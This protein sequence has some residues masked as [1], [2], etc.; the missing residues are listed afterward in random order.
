MV[1]KNRDKKSNEFARFGRQEKVLLNNTLDLEK[2]WK[3]RLLAV[4]RAKATFL[5]KLMV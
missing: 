3:V 1:K 2:V 4:A 5:F